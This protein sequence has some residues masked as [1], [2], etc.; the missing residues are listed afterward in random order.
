[1][2]K[3]QQPLRLNWPNLTLPYLYIPSDRLC[4]CNKLTY[5]KAVFNNKE[6]GCHLL[7]QTNGS[8]VHATSLKYLIKTKCTKT[9]ILRK[10]SL[11]FS[12]VQKR[13]RKLLPE[14]RKRKWRKK[15]QRL[16]PIRTCLKKWI[17]PSGR[18]RTPPKNPMMKMDLPH[19]D[20][21][22]LQEQVY[23]CISKLHSVKVYLVSILT[24]FFLKRT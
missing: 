6:Y 11:N 13:P 18:K 9:I 15:L 14:P 8:N 10:V 23:S 20:L 7:A 17:L 3:I 21:V 1:M 19:L 12:G 24:P 22:H 16:R 5:G 4:G 2:T